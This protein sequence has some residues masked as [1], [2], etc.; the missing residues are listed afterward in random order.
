MRPAARSRSVGQRPSQTSSSP[1]RLGALLLVAACVTGPT[2]HGRWKRDCAELDARQIL[3]PSDLVRPRSL[4][5]PYVY[6]PRQ[7]WVDVEFAV[8]D[9][10]GTTAVE[11]TES[12]PTD[13][14]ERSVVAAVSRWR[15]CPRAEVS[16]SYPEK[17]KTRWCFSSHRDCPR[18]NDC[19]LR[20]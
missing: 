10:G 17:I 4:P 15:F 3:F 14:H 8:T 1:A 12:H 9:A 18:C 5:T 19:N 16:V 7:E 11:V 6:A 2:Q 13:R 20:F